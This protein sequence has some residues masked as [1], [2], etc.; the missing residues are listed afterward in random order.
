MTTEA[1]YINDALTWLAD[2]KGLYL[3][4]LNESD[5]SAPNGKLV[6]WGFVPGAGYRTS[7]VEGSTVIEA[8]RARLTEIEKTAT[9]A[10]R[11]LGKE[12][13]KH[14]KTKKTAKSLLKR[15]AS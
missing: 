9:G 6:G 15:L 1:D 4:R 12:A 13:D 8:I 7:T 11:N 2:E 3:W 14:E 5:R 10:Q